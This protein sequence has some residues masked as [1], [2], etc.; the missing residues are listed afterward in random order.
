MMADRHV[1]EHLA[2]MMVK[3]ISQ[4][5]LGAI[6]HAS[7]P[8]NGAGAFVHP[9]LQPGQSSVTTDHGVAN[10]IST[11]IGQSCGGWSKEQR[12]ADPRSYERGYNPIRPKYIPGL[13]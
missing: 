12:H 13:A 6:F 10:S 8:M 11:R 1:D 3:G 4:P 2:E 5:T 7:G 9:A